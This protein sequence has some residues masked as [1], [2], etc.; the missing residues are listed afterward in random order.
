[1]VCADQSKSSSQDFTAFDFIE[2][3]KGVPADI[4]AGNLGL[5]KA[6]ARGAGQNML[7]ENL[8]VPSAHKATAAL[9]LVAQRLRQ[10][11]RSRVCP[12]PEAAGLEHP[13]R[14]GAR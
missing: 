2:L 12:A 7:Q 14:R 6:A 8:P 3:S 4:C 5:L 1:M 11:S 13:E 9:R 10:L